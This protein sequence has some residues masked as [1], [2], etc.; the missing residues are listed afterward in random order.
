MQ[1]LTAEQIA[2]LAEH[3]DGMANKRLINTLYRMKDHSRLYPINNNFNATKRAIRKA[4]NF[5]RESGIFCCGLQYCYQLESILS[6]I[7]NNCI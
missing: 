2:K 1:Y 3:K 6:E 5:Q 7:V 4:R